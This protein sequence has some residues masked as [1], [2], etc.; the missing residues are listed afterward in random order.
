MAILSGVLIFI[1]IS[2]YL[3]AYSVRQVLVR[4]IS[5]LGRWKLRFTC[6][7]GGIHLPFCPECGGGMHYDSSL[8]RYVCKSC[9]LSLTYQ[10]LIE[11]KA[12]LQ[13]SPNMD[14]SERRRKRRKE[15]LDWW[16]ARRE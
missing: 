15:Y 3:K 12:K 5:A 9:G 11:M 13:D 4:V 1:F 10:E 2:T 7:G 8:K 14:E 16:F 6:L